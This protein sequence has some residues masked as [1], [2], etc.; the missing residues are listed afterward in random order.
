MGIGPAGRQLLEI[1]EKSNSDRGLR[2]RRQ[3]DAVCPMG[4][5]I[6]QICELIEMFSFPLLEK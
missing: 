1:S 5:D 6:R 3:E 2:G 4:V